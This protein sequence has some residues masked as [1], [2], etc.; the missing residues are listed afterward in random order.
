MSSYYQYN[1]SFGGRTVLTM[2]ING[3]AANSTYAVRVDT[4][5]PSRSSEHRHSVK[6][7]PLDCEKAPSLKDL[8][9]GCFW[10]E[11][12][13][14]NAIVPQSKNYDGKKYEAEKQLSEDIFFYILAHK[15]LE[16][17]ADLTTTKRSPL[18][19]SIFS[20]NQK[21]DLKSHPRRIRRSSPIIETLKRKR[22]PSLSIETAP[23]IKLEYL[24]LFGNRANHLFKFTL[25]CLKF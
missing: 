25:Y 10:C 7:F 21:K 14:R 15:E 2:G 5:D 9:N 1:W 18:I 17:Y 16:D 8:V 12:A 24:V 3:I 20:S 19:L 11:I 4:P 22:C 6:E 13:I 23:S